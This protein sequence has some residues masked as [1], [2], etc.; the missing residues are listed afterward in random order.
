MARKGYRPSFNLAGFCGFGRESL[1]ARR[2][3]GG[4]GEALE[5]HVEA[6]HTRL[7]K[8]DDDV[9]RFKPHGF[10]VQSVFANG[11][12]KRAEHIRG[13]GV[14][15]VEGDA[16]FRG[17]GVKDQRADAI[18][19]ITGIQVATGLAGIFAGSGIGP[20]RIGGGELGEM[21]RPELPKTRPPL[22]STYEP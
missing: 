2:R 6:L 8:P 5:F 9:R 14:D 1:V 15:A 17:I 11:K 16:G 4:N 7:V 22:P 18:P 3:F 10:D 19:F 13:A 12:L 20:P 21:S